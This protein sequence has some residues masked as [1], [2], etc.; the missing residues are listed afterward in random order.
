MSRLN[1]VE[2]ALLLRIN[3]VEH[4]GGMSPLLQVRF[5]VRVALVLVPTGVFFLT[6]CPDFLGVPAQKNPSPL[7]DY[8]RKRQ[9][10]LPRLML[11]AAFLTIDS[12]CT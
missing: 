3:L 5:P 4:Q 6:S 2:Q 12:G 9:K 11:G 1:L 10:T 8:L 7:A